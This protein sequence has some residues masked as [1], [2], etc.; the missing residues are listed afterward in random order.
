MVL[1]CVDGSKSDWRRDL[2]RFRRI[3]P[4]EMLLVLTQQDRWSQTAEQVMIRA[5]RVFGCP[6][7]VTSATTGHGLDEVQNRVD[8]MSLRWRRDSEGSDQLALTERHRQSI[9]SALMALQEAQR[10]ALD[11]HDEVAAMLLRSALEQLGRAESDR[12]DEQVLD[13]IFSHFCVGK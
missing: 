6:C 4:A 8:E 9:Q 7:L 5:R 13:R 1:F 10:E 12:V 11:G 3:S 2:E